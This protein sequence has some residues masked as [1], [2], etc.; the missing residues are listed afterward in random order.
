MEEAV[1]GEGVPSPVGWYSIVDRN[2]RIMPNWDKKY[3]LSPRDLNTMDHLEELIQSGITSLK[4]EGRMKRPEYV[5]TIV[6]KYRKALDEG[7]KAINNRDRIDISQIFNRQFTKGIMLGDFGRS[8]ISYDR[9]D[10]R[11]I[12]IGKVV[13]IDKNKVYIKLEEDLNKGDGIELALEKGG[14]KGIKSR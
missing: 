14:Y 5:A 10:N 12:L 11:G 7:I 9:P 8:F 4:V 2:G 3:L 6:S 1:I 13:D